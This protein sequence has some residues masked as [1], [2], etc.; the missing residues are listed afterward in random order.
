M[1][2]K[3]EVRVRRVVAR[4]LPRSRKAKHSFSRIE[5]GK[6]RRA[7]YG[8]TSMVAMIGAGAR[9]GIEAHAI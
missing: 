4:C 9:A 6:V 8:R 7:E 3:I 2:L 1:N 5:H